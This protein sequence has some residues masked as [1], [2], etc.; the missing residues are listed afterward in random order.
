MQTVNWKQINDNIVNVGQVLAS[1][2]DTETKQNVEFVIVDNNGNVKNINMPNLATH[3]ANIKQGAVDVNTVEKLIT[4]KSMKKEDIIN[5]VNSNIKR[6]ETAVKAANG[7][8]GKLQDLMNQYYSKKDVDAILTGI[9]SIAN[10]AN[11]D[12]QNAILQVK[13][14]AS[15]IS[16]LTSK[17]NSLGSKLESEVS[18]VN[19]KVTEVEDSLNILVMKDAGTLSVSRRYAAETIDKSFTVKLPSNPKDGDIIYLM[20]GSYN[21]QN[22]P[23]TIDRNGKQINGKSENLICDV[24][25]FYVVMRYDNN[26]GS[27][28][29]ANVVTK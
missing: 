12:A 29:M 21:A 10:E 13:I 6:I 20:D 18:D 14:N 4:E 7:D 8:T 5:Y 16:D 1:L 27:W 15:N 2:V 19:G 25:G 11:K 28:F 24:N 26:K 9:K 17:V 23:I 3:L 22:N